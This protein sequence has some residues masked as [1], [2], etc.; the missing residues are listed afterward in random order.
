MTH[1]DALV[2]ASFKY[3]L[4]KIHKR[5]ENTEHEESERA[6]NARRKCEFGLTR[7][8]RWIPEEREQQRGRYPSEMA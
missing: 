2:H 6:W 7:G 5:E 1:H 3:K 4:Q 8:D